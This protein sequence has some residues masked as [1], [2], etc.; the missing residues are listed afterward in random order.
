MTKRL[1]QWFSFVLLYGVFSL[2]AWGEWF[3]QQADIMGTQVRVNLWHQDGEEA[4]RVIARVL[5]DMRGVDARLSPYKPD[6]ELSRINR[7]AGVGEQNISDEMMQLLDKSL[8]YSGVTRGAFDISF[9]SV[10]QHYDY[11]N[12][13]QP[14]AVHYEELMPAV[15]Y[16]GVELIGRRQTVRFNHPDMQLDLG[17]IAKGYA[18]DRAVHIIESAGI[19]HASVSA[20]GDSRLLGDKQGR[21]WIVGVKHPRA[22]AQTGRLALTIPL[23]NVAVSTSGDYERYF[24]DPETGERVHHI[25]NPS[26]GRSASDVSSVTVMGPLAIDTDA[27]STSVFVLGIEKGLALVNQLRGF[28]AVIIDR[29]LKLHYSDGLVQPPES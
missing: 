27:L 13:K 12:K 14:E 29:D 24:I 25:L 6:S 3:D 4:Q 5:D 2:P 11:R 23:D 21:P 1:C 19:K 10:G 20:G 18:V 15:D 28:D 8:Y 26:T 22:T 7:L 16:R 9:A 17:G